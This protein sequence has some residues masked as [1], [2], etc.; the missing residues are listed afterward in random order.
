MNGTNEL[1]WL[2]NRPRSVAINIFG[3][4]NSD[5]PPTVLISHLGKDAY[6]A[7]M[8]YFYLRE[9][10]AIRAQRNSDISAL[11]IYLAIAAARDAGHVGR[12]EIVEFGSTLFSTIDKIKSC[13]TP[14]GT[15]LDWR[16]LSFVGVEPLETLATTSKLLHPELDIEIV[17]HHAQ[18]G[19]SAGL[20]LERSF[21]ATAYGF[22]S[23]EDLV[24]WIA[25]SSLGIHGIW[26]S[27]D[28]ISQVT[29][30]A[31]KRVLLVGMDEFSTRLQ[32]LGFAT[33]LIQATKLQ[34]TDGFFY[35]AWLACFSKNLPF[36]D[37]LNGMYQRAKTTLGPSQ[38]RFKGLT[39]PFCT[40]SLVAENADT[41]N[42]YAGMRLFATSGMG[43][44][45]FGP[46]SFNFG[47]VELK[48]LVDQY[49]AAA[50]QV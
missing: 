43:I 45:Q 29:Q 3:V 13:E 38:Q 27:G 25:R 28:G 46:E 5:G 26:L 10:F 36:F 24:T 41:S 31:G 48:S 15:K 2:G 12:I 9:L 42:R 14:P 11:L 34:T 4:L 40:L 44:E 49:M 17:P 6:E 33:V 35:E 7:G 50:R 18:V 47:T 8:L 32:S 16:D 20:R 23:C 22:D 19:P 21:Q 39:E 1:E 37:R 30:L